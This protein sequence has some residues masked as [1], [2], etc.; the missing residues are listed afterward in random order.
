MATPQAV[1]TSRWLAPEIINPSRGC[2][3]TP[4]TETKPGDVFSFAMLAVEVFTGRVPF[5][6]ERNESVARRVSDGDRPKMPGDA[7]QAGLTNEMWK[8]LE[9]CWQQDPNK[10]PTI[11]EVVM[12]WQRFVDH[13]GDG[14]GDVFT[15]YVQFA[16]SGPV[17]GSI[18]TLL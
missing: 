11:E 13:D 4:I 5:A 8:F 12:R 17:F 1:G 9:S 7:R 6:E 18:L 3:G 14:D 16:S 10:R 15:E 2:N